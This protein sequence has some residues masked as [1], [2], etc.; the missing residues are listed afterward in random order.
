M[1]G[2]ESSTINSNGASSSSWGH[3]VQA[4]PSQLPQGPAPP[5]ADPASLLDII[6]APLTFDAVAAGGMDSGV[7]VLSAAPPGGVGG[8]TPKPGASMLANIHIRLLDFL[9]WD[10]ARTLTCGREGKQDAYWGSLLP[11]LGGGGDSSGHGDVGSGH[12]ASGDDDEFGGAPETTLAGLRGSRE[13]IQASPHGFP[14]L[15][16]LVAIHSQGVFRRVEPRRTAAAQG[17]AGLATGRD[18]NEDERSSIPMQA[19]ALDPLGEVIRILRHVMRSEESRPFLGTPTDA[20][21]NPEGMVTDHQPRRP[22]DLG[23]ILKRAESGWYDMDP[24][25]QVRW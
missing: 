12:G 23:T 9:A 20:D 19:I 4:P 15:L 7:G 14:E 6:P 22:L 11:S 13:L 2:T 17:F 5:L 8:P 16:R 10:R 1:E 18:G 24:G 21:V 3:Q 25:S